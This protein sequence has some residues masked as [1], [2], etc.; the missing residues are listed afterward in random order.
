MAQ[1]Y[2]T[3]MKAVEEYIYDPSDAKNECFGIELAI[4]NQDIKMF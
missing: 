2:I 3:P 4:R 1:N